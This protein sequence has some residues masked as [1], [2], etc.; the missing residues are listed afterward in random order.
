KR[1][2]SLGD[3]GCF[4]NPKF[5]AFLYE[6]NR[7]FLEQGKLRLQ[8]TAVDGEPVAFD[9]GYTNQDGVFLY[10]TGFDPA[11]SDLSP[12][13]LHLQASILK[14]IEEGYHFFDFLRGDEPYKA[15]FRT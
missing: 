7:Q 6:A 8:W 13:R 1:R 12:G 2:H 4:A 9:A 3:S 14:A 5:G 10:Q 11:W 15:H